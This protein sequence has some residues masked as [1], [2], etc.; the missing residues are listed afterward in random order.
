[1]SGN[2]LIC[3]EGL[4]WIPYGHQEHW[5]IWSGP[6]NCTT[7]PASGNY[8]FTII[9]SISMSFKLVLRFK[10]IQNENSWFKCKSTNGN[11]RKEKNTDIFSHEKVPRNIVICQSFIAHFTKH[12]SQLNC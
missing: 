5:L 2:P 3:D 11:F 1:M 4:Q 12:A 7:M 8:N 6:E 10:F 9:N